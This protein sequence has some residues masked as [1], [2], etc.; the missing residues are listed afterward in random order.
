MQNLTLFPIQLTSVL[1]SLQLPFVNLVLPLHRSRHFKVVKFWQR[2]ECEINA[3][4]KV[5]CSVPLLFWQIL[6]QYAS[7]LLSGSRVYKMDQDIRSLLSGSL[8]LFVLCYR[9]QQMVRK[10]SKYIK[11]TSLS[12]FNTESSKGKLFYLLWNDPTQGVCIFFSKWLLS[13]IL[14]SQACLQVSRGGTRRT[15]RSK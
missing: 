13:S 14:F 3:E 15:T 1:F 4:W 8:V 5:W 7:W 10:S 6:A 12:P 9:D 11:L 2:K